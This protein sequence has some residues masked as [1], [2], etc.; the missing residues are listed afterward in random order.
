MLFKLKTLKK[1]KKPIKLFKNF[2]LL[3]NKGKWEFYSA[4]E[5]M[6]NIYI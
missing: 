6:E 4:V 2:L 3:L 5:K 1:K